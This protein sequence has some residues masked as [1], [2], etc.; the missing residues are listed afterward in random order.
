MTPWASLAPWAPLAQE[1]VAAAARDKAVAAHRR[2]ARTPPKGRARAPPPPLNGVPLPAAVSYTER[3]LAGLGR[4]PSEAGYA[5][6][7]LHG[8]RGVKM[9]D[10]RTRWSQWPFEP[11]I[12]THE[13]MESSLSGAPAKLPPPV[14]RRALISH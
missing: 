3:R 11:R 2:R 8:L 14:P 13:K 1:A 4:R 10:G 7:Y 5:D 12:V 6:E 9:H